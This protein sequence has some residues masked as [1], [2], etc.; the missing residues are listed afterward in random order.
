VDKLVKAPLNLA[1]RK[2]YESGKP[3]GPD[4]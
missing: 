4:Q 1:S 3:D 2:L